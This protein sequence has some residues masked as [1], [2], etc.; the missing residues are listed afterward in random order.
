MPS[1]LDVYDVFWFWKS[2]GL[3][4]AEWEEYLRKKW[5]RKNREYI[6]RAKVTCKSLKNSFKC[7][8][9]K[10]VGMSQ[11]YTDEDLCLVDISQRYTETVFCRLMDFSQR[12]T[13]TCFI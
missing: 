13:G 8:R 2:A 7:A 4:V 6:S 1:I 11:R 3:S 12:Y 9:S 5:K 10:M